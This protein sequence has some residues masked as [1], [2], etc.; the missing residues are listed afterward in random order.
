LDDLEGGV[1]EGGFGGDF[2]EG[3]IPLMFHSAKNHAL[4]HAEGGQE[5]TVLGAF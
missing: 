2:Q 3:I 4:T 1:N 5:E